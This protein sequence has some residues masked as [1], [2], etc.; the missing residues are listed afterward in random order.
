MCA[1][2]ALRERGGR[3]RCL[4]KGQKEYTDKVLKLAPSY[5]AGNNN[6]YNTRWGQN[7]K[8]NKTKKRGTKSM[9]S[10]QVLVKQGRMSSKYDSVQPNV[11]GRSCWKPHQNVAEAGEGEKKVSAVCSVRLGGPE[12]DRLGPSE[13][14][15]GCFSQGQSQINSIKYIPGFPSIAPPPLLP[16]KNRK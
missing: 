14:T 2:E 4:K 13:E 1:R 11:C 12:I 8:M 10:A 15:K 5:E 16:Q 9:C 3:E 6:M 7:R